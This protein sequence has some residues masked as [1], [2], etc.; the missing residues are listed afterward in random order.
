MVPVELNAGRCG[1]RDHRPVPDAAGQ[2]GGRA[3]E[4]GHRATSA[5]ARCS[6]SPVAACATAFRTAGP[7]AA[8]GLDGTFP[9]APNQILS[10]LPDGPAAQ[11]NEAE[12]QLRLDP[13]AQGLPIKDPQAADS[14]VA[15]PL[16]VHQSSNAI[17]CTRDVCAEGRRRDRS[18]QRRCRVAGEVRRPDRR[19]RRTSCGRVRDAMKVSPLRPQ[20]F[21]EI[22]R[23]LG[24]AQGYARA[25]ELLELA[26]RP[27]PVTCSTRRPRACTTSRGTTGS[28][29]RRSLHHIK[30]A[31]RAVGGA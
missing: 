24:T 11:P 14:E 2:G 31:D 8:L 22:G 25:A 16:R 7:A 13:R 20:S 23:T 28:T 1:R 9:P 15:E 4:P 5:P 10:L 12:P 3:G 18:D 26:A 17:E 19:R 30:K 6:S 21:G 27:A 29:T